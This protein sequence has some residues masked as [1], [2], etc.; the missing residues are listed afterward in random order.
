M[1]NARILTAILSTILLFTCFATAQRSDGTLIPPCTYAVVDAPF[2]A[3]TELVRTEILANG[4]QITHKIAG[5]VLRDS[6]GR[7]RFEQGGEQGYSA[8][9]PFTEILIFDVVG[10]QVFRF[11][12]KTRTAVVTPMGPAQAGPVRVP[13]SKPIVLRLG[14]QPE[15]NVK[16]GLAPQEIAGLMADGTRTT[17]TI[18]AGR[19]GNDTDVTVTDE[20]WISRLYRM[21]VKRMHD[22][23]LH[24]RLV[25]QVTHFEAGEPDPKLFEVPV[26]YQV[27]EGQKWVSSARPPAA[28]EGQS[29]TTATA[30]T[31][32]H[33]PNFDTER[34][35]ANDLYMAGKPL[36]ALPLYQDLCQQDQTIAV[37][38]ERHA[39]GLLAKVMT[40]QD[41]TEKQAVMAQGLAEIRRAQS[42]GDN[43]P[44]VQSILAL[45]AKSPLGSIFSGVPLTVAYTYRTTPEAQAVEKEGEAAYGQGDWSVAAE[46]YKQAYALDPKWYFAALFAGDAYFHLHDVADA[47]QWFQKAIDIDPDCE[48]AYRYWG[49]TLFKN[50][51]REGAKSKFEE[52]VV[53]EPYGRTAMLGLQQ[54]AALMHFQIVHSQ[55]VIPRFTISGGK[56]AEDPAIENETGDGHASWLVYE[57]TRVAHGAQMQFQPIVAGATDVNGVLHPSGYRHS[58]AEESESI[59]A[60]LADV[61]RKLKAGAVTSDRLEPS[62][63]YLLE[64]DKGGMID[65]WILLNAAD[66]GIRADYPAYRKDHRDLLAAYI[67]RYILHPAPEPASTPSSK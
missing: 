45:Q 23:P 25:I 17:Y 1:L 41:A 22:D 63:K 27:S 20:L 64:I 28:A 60:M 56:L 18:P 48:T 6:A 32:Q 3:T 38:A 61:Q 54:W 31:P 67:D 36:E 37:F 29:G 7:Q 43:S 62:L 50:G 19:E 49:D 46:K 40:I 11:T 57:Q 26:G 8:S 39:A 15:T 4:E 24:G 10:R 21:P 47:G 51:D 30:P 52:A 53:A 9:V 59:H 2:T 16:E 66:A 44:Y 34:K 55:V 14:Q 5:R 58:L 33:G 12:D 35:Q 65:C 13:A 42:L